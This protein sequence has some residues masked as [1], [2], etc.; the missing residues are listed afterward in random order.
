MRI[1]AVCPALAKHRTGI[2]SSVQGQQMSVGHAGWYGIIGRALTLGAPS[3]ASSG[4]SARGNG[5]S[6]HHTST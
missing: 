4:L 2:F 1:K 5:N 6:C 3:V